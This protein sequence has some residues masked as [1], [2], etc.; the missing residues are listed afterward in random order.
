VPKVRHAEP[1]MSIM[2]RE[3]LYP[4]LADPGRAT[5]VG[6]TRGRLTA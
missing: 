6:T 3:A 4:E 5:P 1:R 2:F